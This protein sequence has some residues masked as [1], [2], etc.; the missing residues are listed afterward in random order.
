MEHKVKTL[1]ETMKDHILKEEAKFA[2]YDRA[3]FGDKELG[4]KGLIE[5]NREMYDLLMGARHVGGF[6]GGLKGSLGWLLLIA[7]VVATLKGWWVGIIG[8]LISIR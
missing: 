3:I 1:E 6:F 2:A 7:A 4:Q 8:Y 5:M